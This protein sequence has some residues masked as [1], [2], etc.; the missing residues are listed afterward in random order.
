M[1]EAERD[2]ATSQ[3]TQAAQGEACLVQLLPLQEPQEIDARCFHPLWMVTVTA[4]P[5]TTAS[6]LA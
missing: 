6:T 5:G 4:V 2:A 1:K 3:A